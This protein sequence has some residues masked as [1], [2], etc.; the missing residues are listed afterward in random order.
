M[1]EK[2]IRRSFEVKTDGVVNKRKKSEKE[3]KIVFEEVDF[4]AGVDQIKMTLTMVGK[5]A[6]FTTLEGKGLISE[7]NEEDSPEVDL[8]LTTSAQQKLE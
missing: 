8:V 2:T 5:P 7:I 3:R 4:K 1:T 6:A